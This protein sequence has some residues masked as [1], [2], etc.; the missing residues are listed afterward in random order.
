MYMI[1]ILKI[2]G[3][4]A[5]VKGAVREV[6]IFALSRKTKLPKSW[7][8]QNV[9]MNQPTII[10][11]QTLKSGL[12]KYLLFTFAIDSEIGGIGFFQSSILQLFQ[13]RSEI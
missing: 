2:E 13:K 7:S 12:F 10:D 6:S 1:M 9:K 4:Y 11:L 3:W 5:F 8:L